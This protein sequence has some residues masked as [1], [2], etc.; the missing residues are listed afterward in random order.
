LLI[1]A[2]RLQCTKG[3]ISYF[4]VCAQDRLV[5]RLLRAAR[6]CP[7]SGL[8][9]TRAGSQLNGPEAEAVGG[10]FKLCTTTVCGYKAHSDVSRAAAVV[11]GRRRAAHY[12][13]VAGVIDAEYDLAVRDDRRHSNVELAST[14][15]AIAST[16]AAVFL[17]KVLI[18]ESSKI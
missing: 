12:V 3:V 10:G 17:N 11:S 15:A 14:R 13:Q 2:R 1:S 18:R 8:K 6:V 5:V 7:P 9:S 16:L 4:K